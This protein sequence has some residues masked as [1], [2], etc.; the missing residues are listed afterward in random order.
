[1]VVRGKTNIQF[2]FDTERKSED[3]QFYCKSGS[4]ETA[5]RRILI[6]ISVWFIYK[7]KLKGKM[8][9]S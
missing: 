9:L 5:I 1:M 7:F 8:C 6:D 4:T 2:V 3:V